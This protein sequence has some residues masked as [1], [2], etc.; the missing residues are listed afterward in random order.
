[1]V[2]SFAQVSEQ[3]TVWVTSKESNLVAGLKISFNMV[4]FSNNKFGYVMVI[5]G[6]KFVV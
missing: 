2:S 5:F 6:P 4:D 3:M 1:M